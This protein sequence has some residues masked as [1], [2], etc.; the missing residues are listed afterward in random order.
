MKL[1]F[2]QHAVER[3]FERGITVEDVTDTLDSGKIIEG[4]PTDSPYPSALWLGFVRQAPLHV[5]AAD[6]V[7]FGERIIS[8][9]YR[10]GH[11]QWIGGWTTRRKL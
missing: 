5:V 4:Y 11:E 10:P 2:R 8:T 6:N 1:V 3:M 7:H 9:A